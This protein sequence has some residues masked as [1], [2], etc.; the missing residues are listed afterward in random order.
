MDDGG[1]LPPNFVHDVLAVLKDDDDART[2]FVDGL[3]KRLHHLSQDP[4]NPEALGDLL[5]F[6]RRWAVSVASAFHPTRR[7]ALEDSERRIAEGDLGE[8]A[9]TSELR[10]LIRG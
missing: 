5:R 4:T 8:P 7:A 10:A 3:D 1:V 9:A 6:G 2:E